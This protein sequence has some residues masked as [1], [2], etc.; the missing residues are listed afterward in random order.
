[1]GMRGF[2]GE[3]IL[4]T[5]AVLASPMGLVRNKRG[6]LIFLDS[7]NYRIRKIGTDKKITTIAGTGANVQYIE[8]EKAT[9]SP[10]GYATAIAMNDVEEIFFYVT[11]FPLAPVILKIGTDG[12]IR[13]FAGN[14]VNAF[15]G[16]DGPAL[17]ASLM[18]SNGLAIGK[19]GELYLTDTNTNRVRMVSPHSGIISTVAGGG[20]K[21]GGP[22]DETRL[23]LPYSLAVGPRGD[24]FIGDKFKVKQ[25]YREVAC[26]GIDANEPNVCSGHGECVDTD[27]CICNEGY[28]GEMCSGLIVKC[29]DIESTD[30]NVCSGHGVCSSTNNCTCNAG[31][32]GDTCSK[33]I[34]CYGKSFNDSTVCSGHGTCSSPDVCTCDEGYSGET[35]SLFQ[36]FGIQ[37]TNPKVCSGHGT[38]TGADVC[39]CNKGYTGDTCSKKLKSSAGK[40]EANKALTVVFSTV[41]VALTVFSFMA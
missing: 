29:Y 41:A 10:I 9:K 32:T 21:V 17:E 39:T 25:M 12:R 16:D 33:L 6:E 1:M 37:P 36:C 23:D 18:Y 14:G 2:F 27:N 15:S 20:N 3:N 22:A 19:A 31:Y 28:T 38:C 24:L 30:S 40:L 4:A 11:Y 26:F 7:N 13:R 34:M 35:C 8:G 5:D